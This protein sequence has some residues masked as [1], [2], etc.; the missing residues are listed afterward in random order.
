M[1]QRRCRKS[2]S[3]VASRL[4][5]DNRRQ[6]GQGEESEEGRPLIELFKIRHLSSDT[7]SDLHKYDDVGGMHAKPCQAKQVLPLSALCPNMPYVR[8]G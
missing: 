4:L 2:E 1:T 3:E 8:L 7:P 6:Q 5:N